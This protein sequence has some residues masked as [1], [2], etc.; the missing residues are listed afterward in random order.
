MSQPD[1]PSDPPPSPPVLIHPCPPPTLRA[2]VHA[3]PE[4]VR[5]L[6]QVRQDQR[7]RADQIEPHPEILPREPVMT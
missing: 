4:P 1:P 5:S 3:E 2:E 7:S 6:A